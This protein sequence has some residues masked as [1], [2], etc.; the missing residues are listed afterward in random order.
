[1]AGVGSGKIVIGGVGTIEG[2]GVADANAA[3]FV[4]V[5]AD[6]AVVDAALDAACDSCLPLG[7]C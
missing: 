2:V 3:A 1:M 6:V 4:V 7:Y 5:L